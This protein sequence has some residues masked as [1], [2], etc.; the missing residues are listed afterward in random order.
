MN[1]AGK[2]LGAEDLSAVIGGQQSSSCTGLR[3]ALSKI[4]H[5]SPQWRGRRN[6]KGW[7]VVRSLYMDHCRRGGGDD[8]GGR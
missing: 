4:A 8:G 7:Y 3:N 1:I 6:P 2:K 5:S